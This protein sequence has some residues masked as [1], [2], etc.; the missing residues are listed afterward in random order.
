VTFTVWDEGIG[1]NQEDAKLLFKPFV[2]L[3]ASLAREFSGTG[4]GLALVAQMIRLHGG[5]VDLTSELKAGSRFII[6][7]PWR[8]ATQSGQTISPV[9]NLKDTPSQPAD[10][11]KLPHDKHAV[12]ILVVDDTEV[13]AQLISDYLQHKGYK[14]EIAHNGSQA[15]LLAKQEHPHIILMDVMM[16]VM[17]GL[18]ATKQIRADPSLKDITIIGLTALAMPNDRQNCIEAGMNDHLSKPIQLPDLIKV[19]ERY[20]SPQPGL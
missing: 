8:A 11:P 10:Q 16:P 14:T 13:A 1:I 9:Q 3:N 7:L 12:K 15:V 18:D 20:L 2:Q 19:I 4:L 5:H 6:S 17:N